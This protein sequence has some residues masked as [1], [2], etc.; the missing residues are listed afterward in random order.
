MRWDLFCRVVDNFGD[1]GVCWRLAADLADRG[2]SVRL[3]VDDARAL[4]WMAPQGAPGVAVF[5]WPA[6]DD[7]SI[8]PREAVI[9]A[10]GCHL[11]TGF[12]RRMAMR[13]APPL[14]I[15]LEYLSAEDYVERNHGLRSPQ[16]SG[17]GQGLDKWFFYPG[18]TARSGGLL[19]EQG[20]TARQT[21][22][23]A[24]AWR[25]A[26][27]IP[28]EAGERSVS[29][30][31]YAN[32]ALAALLE[33]LSVAP[34][35]LL[36]TPGL[37]TQQ[38]K[39]ALGSSAR[40]GE[41]RIHYLQALPQPDYDHLLWSC[42][43]NLVR[44]EDSFVRAQWAGRPFL[45]QIYPQHDRV[46]A[47]KL[48]AFNQRFLAGAAPDLAPAVSR[49]ALAWNGLGGVARR[50]GGGAGFELPSAALWPQWQAHCR[51]WRARLLAL[52]DLASSLRAFVH[53]RL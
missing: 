25:R 31:C 14:W 2:D 5:G 26:K 50:P 49:A 42:D 45:W 19:R 10:F 53:E 51:S 35:R 12:V 52:P 18:F 24:Q 6:D 20:L 40:Q 46:H 15:N 21:A 3:W 38:V 28:L 36:V 32:P 34:T 23:D 47:A 11:P 37:A 44:G 9:E 1:I 17:P 16:L 41:L 4:A 8:D 33:A 48:E 30:F 7:E 43:L 39:A 22:F 13:A 29:L 27:G